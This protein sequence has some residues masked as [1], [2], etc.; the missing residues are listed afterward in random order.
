[1]RIQYTFRNMESS[2]GMKNYA[3]DKI[4]KLQKY[5]RAPLHAEITFHTERH[6]HCCDLSLTADGHQYSGHEQQE[7]MYASIDLVVDKID[8]QIRDLKSSEVQRKRHTTR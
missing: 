3:S 2:D 1:M 6:L 5:L 4:S 8:R 7:N